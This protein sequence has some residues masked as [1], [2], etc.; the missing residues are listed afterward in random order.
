MSNADAELTG[1]IPPPPPPPGGR[2]AGALPPLAPP[3]VHATSAPNPPPLDLQT[4]L[5][6]LKAQVSRGR[7]RS[8][9]LGLG[10]ALALLIG[11]ACWMAYYASAVLGYAPVDPEITLRRDS[12]DPERLVFVYRPLGT[13][14]IGFRRT[15]S[16]RDTELL[17]RVVP[18]AVGEEQ[19]FQWRASGA[20][21][22]DP[23]RV[24][25]R[26]GLRV[27]SQEV[28]VPPRPPTLLASLYAR[29]TLA[30]RSQW[31]GRYGGSAESE[32]AV[33]E[34]LRWL[35]RHQA[36]DGS[37]SNR[38]LG[39]DSPSKCDKAGPCTGPGG[40]YEVALT[41]L[42]LLAF[43][44]GG[45]YAFNG[46]N[47]SDQVRKGLD[48]LVARQRADG[49]LVGPSSPP[50][51]FHQYYMYEHG[52]ATFALAE[53]C[54]VALAAGG[55]TQPQYAEAMQRAVQFIYRMQHRDGGWRYTPDLNAPSDSS[56]S[57]WQV[58]AL[59]SAKEAG[60]KIEPECI[61]S[62]RRFFDAQAMPRNGRTA[63]Q[64]RNVLTEATTGVGM[65]A[66]QFLL[67][68]PD[69]PLV[70]EAAAYLADFIEAAATAGPQRPRRRAKAPKQTDYYLWYNCT[71]AMFQAGGPAWQRWNDVVRDA[72]IDLQ[73]R[74]G[75]QRGSW[76]PDAQ[77]G[78]QGGRIYSTALAILTLEV[79]YRYALQDESSEPAVD[80]RAPAGFTKDPA[81]SGG[82]QV[83]P[84]PAS[85]PL[86][87]PSR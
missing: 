34:G 80:I 50:G 24:T 74:D 72:I 29:R 45:H 31:I 16:E 22:G 7:H 59:K 3:V 78:Q 4:R 21:P 39:S 79:Y 27:V 35:A 18:S 66:R 53:A 15:D 43:Q 19:T 42:A 6:G 28:L 38:C 68:E 87:E 54:A 73:E 32:Q 46:N 61:E 51:A 65:L 71:L 26:R 30:N 47:Y 75:C 41:G 85:P 63:Y 11:L 36:D 76:G 10:A 8:L 64:R 44:A 83:T 14:T 9:V 23:V 55:P 60:M 84:L 56:V 82:V 5:E 49:A 52:I 58:L 81:S 13:G 70:R 48:W 40:D 62:I 12:V 33:N 69:G 20:E 25:Y 17:D 67:D 1:K 57:G 86:Q 2:G 77:W 37:W